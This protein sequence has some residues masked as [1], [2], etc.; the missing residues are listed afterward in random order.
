MRRSIS[1]NLTGW[2]KFEAW[3]TDFLGPVT[4]SAFQSYHRAEN[5][6]AAFWAAAAVHWSQ[7]TSTA[8]DAGKNESAIERMVQMNAPFVDAFEAGLWLWCVSP[9]EAIL[10]PRP[11]GP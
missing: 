1:K 10:A 8:E 9:S 2:D 6:I 7:V 11:P 5:F 3:L 4:P